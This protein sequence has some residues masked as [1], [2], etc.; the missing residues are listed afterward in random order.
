LIVTAAIIVAALA[1]FGAVA[2]GYGLHAL[3]TEQLRRMRAEV[4]SQIGNHGIWV[5]AWLVGI[6]A[7]R[8]GFV[9]SNA[10]ERA[11]GGSPEQILA[12]WT[13][14]GGRVLSHVA[15]PD[16]ISESE[17]CDW[18][19]HTSD[20]LTRVRISRPLGYRREEVFVLVY[21]ST[22]GPPLEAFKASDL[23]AFLAGPGVLG[24]AFVACPGAR[25]GAPVSWRAVAIGI[26]VLLFIGLAGSAFVVISGASPSAG[27]TTRA[28]SSAHGPAPLPPATSPA[29]GG[30]GK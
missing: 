6:A 27:G 4:A 3:R 16:L 8:S 13:E 9:R 22:R 12:L 11:G 26:G 28:L 24:A 17:A 23:K 19:T 21:A 29:A 25:E 2:G 1:F 14:V 5:G 15:G 10:V 20:A 7:E 30:R 18:L